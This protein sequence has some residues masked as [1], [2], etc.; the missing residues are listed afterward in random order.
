MDISVYNYY[1]HLCEELNFTAA[2]EK[3]F[4]SRQAM[5]HALKTLENFYGMPLIIN[6]HNHLSLTPDGQILYE[7]ALKLIKVKNEMD[8]AMAKEFK[9]NTSIA[10]SSSLI[11]Y[12]APTILDAVGKFIEKNHIKSEN[13]QTVLNSE[14]LDGVLSG[15]YSCALIMSM[16]LNDSSLCEIPLFSSSLTILMS[17]KNALAAKS[18]LELSDLNNKK[19]ICWGEP[20]IFFKQLNNDMLT[21]GINAEYSNIAQFYEAS[22]KI[23]NEDYL[24]FDRFPD[25][26]SHYMDPLINKK[27]CN[28]KYRVY[29]ELIALN[30]NAHF[31]RSL[32]SK[33][34]AYYKK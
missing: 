22:A 1:I 19:I 3:S 9:S 12:F 13:V 14:A 29:C 5:Q 7:K 8:Y 28:N 10:I 15:K 26:V 2:A 18:S 17:H 20:D 32:S 34:A 4:I 21:Q 16:S 23:N 6:E 24:G 30:K 31:I 27:L 25:A 11:P 33:L